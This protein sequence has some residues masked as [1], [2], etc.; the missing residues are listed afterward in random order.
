MKESLLGSCS[1]KERLPEVHHEEEARGGCRDPDQDP[2][3]HLHSDEAQDAHRD[4][5]AQGVSCTTQRWLAGL[6][7]SAWTLLVLLSKAQRPMGDTQ[8]HA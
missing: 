8:V 6:T 3:H 4:E 1:V 7:A 5:D 2:P